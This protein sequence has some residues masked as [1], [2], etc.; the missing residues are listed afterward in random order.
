VAGQ[1]APGMS[2]KSPLLYWFRRDLRLSDHPGLSA[3][4]RSGRAV[5]PVFVLDPETEAVGSAAKWRL[6]LGLDVFRE[7]LRAIG[8]D[9]VFRRG[10]ARDV[11]L[12]LAAETGAG[13]VHWTR[14]YDPDA[15]RRDTAVETA[16]A[17]AGI[18]AESHPGHVIFE[19]W[20]IRTKAAGGCY[21]VFTPYWRSLATRDVEPCLDAVERLAAPDGWPGSDR[22]EDWDLGRAMDR[23][24][25]VVRAHVCVGERAARQRL[26]QFLD[27]PVRDYPAGRDR[28]DRTATSGLSE[29]LTCGEISAR[30]VWHAAGAVMRD[31]RIERMTQ[32]RAGALTFRKE[33]A[34][35]EFA[36]HLIHHTPHIVERA[37]RADWN[38]FPWR[39]DTP[40]AERWRR[41]ITGE[42]IVDAAM[43]ELFVTG[44]M[45][46]RA[47]MIVASYLTKHLLTDWRVGLAWFADCL[48]DWDPANN[49]LNWQWA[50]G[51][52]PDASPYFRVFN[53]ATQA[54][55]FDPKAAY[56]RRWIYGYEGSEHEDAAAYFEA[57]PR[58][59]ALSREDPL[60]ERIVGLGEGR[61]R[62][63]EA[64]QRFRAGGGD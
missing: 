13:A 30:E 18:P 50:A 55:R 34:W 45:H 54:D 26:R 40:D 9:L 11:L 7:S 42:P 37:W 47:R 48:I 61:A 5:I 12:A 53:P 59:W 15:R 56:R 3:A 64:Y 62:A 14:L 17:A 38:A 19:P 8:S 6:G 27:G 58:R 51:C 63:L 49:A 32:A 29:N 41:G 16:L 20:T 22:L 60:P 10:A 35:R 24:A 2:D 21:K 28:I 4:A 43:R 33:I 52:G 46:N 57:V 1:I 44:R 36:W 23:G 39:G 31:E 25:A